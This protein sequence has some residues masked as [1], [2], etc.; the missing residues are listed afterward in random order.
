MKTFIT[1]YTQVHSSCSVLVI[2]VV[3]IR[4][5]FLGKSLFGYVAL[6]GPVHM[7][8]NFIRLSVPADFSS[9]NI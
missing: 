6:K 2:C 5:S 7:Y 3:K 1:N 8:P 4:N 9:D